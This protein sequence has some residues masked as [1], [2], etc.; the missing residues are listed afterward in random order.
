MALST[1]AEDGEAKTPPSTA[2]VSMPSPM[3]PACAGSW[4]LP[5][6]L[7]KTTCFALTLA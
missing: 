6:P 7:I 3:K 1:A 2:P 5:P 4:P